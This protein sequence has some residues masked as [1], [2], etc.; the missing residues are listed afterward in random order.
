MATTQQPRHRNN[1]Q[2]PHHY[3]IYIKRRLGEG[4]VSLGLD[5]NLAK[6]SLNRPEGHGFGQRWLFNR[7]CDGNPVVI[8]LFSVL[9]YASS[10][11]M[12]PSCALSPMA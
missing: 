8:W 11:S 12:L 6:I 10:P 2:E 7:F 4:K 5:G 3:L 1:E 9:Q